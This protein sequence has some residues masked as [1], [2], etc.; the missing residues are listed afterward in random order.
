MTGRQV[1]VYLQESTYNTIRELVGPRQI[2]RYINRTLEEKL[3]QEKSKAKK[4]LEEEMIEGYKANA[5]NKKIQSE[6]RDWEETSVQDMFSHLE[7]LESNE[8]DKK[9]K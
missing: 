9:K 7:K 6:L 1:N 5:N 2:S 4:K 8:S 3:I